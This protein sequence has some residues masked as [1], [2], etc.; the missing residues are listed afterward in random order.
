MA[1]T[2]AGLRALEADAASRGER[3]FVLIPGVDVPF[4]SSRLRDGVDDFRRHLDQLIPAD[5]D[6]DLS[7][8]HI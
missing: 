4:H 5:I 3:A 8:I 7:L 2:R 1:G 6:L